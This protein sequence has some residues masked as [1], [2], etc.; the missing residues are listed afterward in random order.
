MS[1]FSY[2]SSWVSAD[3]VDRLKTARKKPQKKQQQK[4]TFI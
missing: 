1:D 2:L 3:E 4:K